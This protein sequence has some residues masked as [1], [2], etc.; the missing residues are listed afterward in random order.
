MKLMLEQG[1]DQIVEWIRRQF[2]DP[3]GPSSSPPLGRPP[4]RVNSQLVCLLASWVF[5]TVCL[6]L[7]FVL[8]VSNFDDAI[9]YLIPMTMVATKITLLKFG[10]LAMFSSRDINFSYFDDVIDDV[11]PRDHG[12][13]P[14]LSLR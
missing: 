5:Y 3:E 2:C 11:I 7:L 6:S 10:H 4:I 1:G 9:N 14:P 8:I 13:A 12:G